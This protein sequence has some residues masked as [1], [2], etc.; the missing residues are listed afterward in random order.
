MPPENL[1]TVGLTP[2]T[3]RSNIGFPGRDLPYMRS[4]K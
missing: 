2:A 1:K 3:G 4:Q